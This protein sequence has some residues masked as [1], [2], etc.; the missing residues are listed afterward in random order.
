M[1]SAYNEALNM[2]AKRDFSSHALRVALIAKRFPLVEVDECL[3]RLMGG[4]LVNDLR[5]ARD[6]TGKLQAELR[7]DRDIAQK[8][9]AAGLGGVEVGQFG[10]SE[11]E[12]GRS[13]IRQ[14]LPNEVSLAKM[15]RYLSNRGYSEE[16]VEMICGE[17]AEVYSGE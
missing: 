17:R 2:L 6:L 15:G 13:L 12:R 14:K 11:L 16:T 7:G 9:D 3:T 5:L 10:A 4:G 1:N 8:L